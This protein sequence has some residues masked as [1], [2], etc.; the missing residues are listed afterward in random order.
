M[1][2]ILLITLS[3]MLAHNVSTSRILSYNFYKNKSKYRPTYLK[4]D[5][6]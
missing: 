6:K 5:S 1:S 3:G 2:D 4:Y